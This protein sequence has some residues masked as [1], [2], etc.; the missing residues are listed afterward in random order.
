MK[1]FMDQKEATQLEVLFLF[2]CL[3]KGRQVHPSLDWKGLCEFLKILLSHIPQDWFMSINLCNTCSHFHGTQ[4]LF[5]F[6]VPRAS[7]LI[8]CP[9]FWPLHSAVGVLSPLMA[10]GIRILLNLDDLSQQTLQSV[11]TN[12]D[13]NWDTNCSAKVHREVREELSNSKSDHT[14]HSIRIDSLR[15]LPLHSSMLQK[16]LSLSNRFS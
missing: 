4:M 6:C 15:I 11:P 13:T 5:K 16:L 9:A 12:D 7:T 2:T 3:K 1:M 10:T 8:Q 14:V